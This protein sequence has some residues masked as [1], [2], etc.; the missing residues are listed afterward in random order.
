MLRI[1]GG[2][3]RGRKLRVPDVAATRPLVERAREGV[4]N[5]LRAE[6]PEAVV[7]DVYAGSGI[8]GLEALSRGASQV[9]AVERHRRAGQ[10]LLDNAKLLRLDDRLRLLQVDAHRLPEMFTAGAAELPRPDLIFFDPP[11][12]DFRDGGPPRK[13]VWSLFCALAGLL[14]AGGAAIVHTPKGI[15]DEEERG[16]LPGIEQRD[17]GSTSLYWWHRNDAS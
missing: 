10:Q 7:W 1:T 6:L 12:K 2:E 4:M 5:H 11:Y 15:L 17:Y 16:S 8:L 9:L 3:H 14:E 13:K